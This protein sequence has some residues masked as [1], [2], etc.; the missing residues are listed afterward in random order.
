MSKSETGKKVCSVFFMSLMS[1]GTKGLYVWPSRG[2]CKFHTAPWLDG[3][4]VYFTIRRENTLVC[5]LITLVWVGVCVI[6][7]GLHFARISLSPSFTACKI[8]SRYSQIKI[9]P[10]IWLLKLPTQF[11]LNL[12]LVLSVISGFSFCLFLLPSFCIYL[13][14]ESYRTRKLMLII[15]EFHCRFCVWPV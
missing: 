14:S 6:S 13:S 1:V 15:S 12:F 5:A 4:C 9:I 10:L 2:W 8:L 11:K 7:H 3:V